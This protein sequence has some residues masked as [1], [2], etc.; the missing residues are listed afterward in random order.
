M[1]ASALS[2]IRID[3]EGV[4]YYL[5]QPLERLGLVQL[6][7]TVLSKQQDGYYLTTPA[8]RLKIM[9]EDVPFAV[10]NVDADAQGNITLTLNDTSR[11]LLNADRRMRY[12]DASIMYVSISDATENMLEARFTLRAYLQIAEYFQQS[13]DSTFVLKSFGATLSLKI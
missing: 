12:S 3:R 2:T 7:G 4:W 6:F 8:E 5:D 13:D 10:V 1:D 9:V 11:L